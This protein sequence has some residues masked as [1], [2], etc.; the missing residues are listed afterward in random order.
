M[1]RLFRLI[2]RE[3]AVEAEVDAELD[4][5]LAL[6]TEALVAQ[7]LSRQE[8]EQEARRQFGPRAAV[9]RSTAAENRASR[10]R[11]HW[12]EW[13]SERIA[14]FGIAGRA[15]R[16]APGFVVAVTLIL[17][18]GIGSSLAA[19]ALL[20]RLLLRAVPIPE[21]DRVVLLVEVTASGQLRLPSFPTVQDW[22][23][24]AGAFE[25]IAYVPGTGIPWR[26]PA[27]VE[28]VPTAFPT[29]E[30]FPLMRTPAE[31]GR[32][33]TAADEASGDRV[34]VLSHSFWKR[35]FG[36]DPKVVGT[37][38]SLSDGAATIVGV[39]PAGF[40]VPFWA[41][42][43]LPLRVVPPAERTAIAQRGNHADSQVLGRLKPGVSIEQARAAMAVVAQRLAREYPAEQG[44]WTGVTMMPIRDVLNDP[45]R[46]GASGLTNP[47]GTVLLFAGAVGL[48]L[49]IGCA[50]VA[51]LTLVRGLARE[52]ELAIRAAIGA[53]RGAL[54]RQLLT[55]STLLAA[56]GGVLGI[57]VASLLL[58]LLK[59]SEVLPR[60]AEVELDLRMVAAT[61]AL[62]AIAA[63]ASGLVPALR[64]TP[65]AL[66]QLVKGGGFHGAT[67][68]SGTAVQRGF[69]AV[70]IGLTVTLLI[71]AALLVRSLDRVLTTPLGFD[72]EN[73]IE[74]T[75]QPRDGPSLTP[76]ATIQLYRNLRDAVARVP[77]VESVAI[78]NHTPGG[79]ASYPTR[80][81]VEGYVSPSENVVPT[82]NYR[83]VSPEYFATMRIPI[84]R[85][86]VFGPEDLAAP[87]GGLVVNESLARRYWPGQNPIGRR[88]TIF[89]SARWLPD[90]GQ[91]IAGTVIGVVGDVRHFGPEVAPPDEVFLPYT[92]T[93]W[94]WTRMVVRVARNPAQLVDPVWRA[95]VTIDPDLPIATGAFRNISP[96]AETLFDRAGPRLQMT[97]VAVGLAGAALLL[98]VVG[99]YGLMAYLVGLRSREIA[100][101]G[102]LGADRAAVLALVMREG[103]AL[104]MVGTS[105]GLTAGW[106]AASSLE[107]LVFGVAVRDL[108][109][110]IAAPVLLVGIAAVAVFIPARRACAVEPAMALKGD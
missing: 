51:G 4:S 69:V 105:L 38:M 81:E 33:L 3:P 46:L 96:V 17:A 19:F 30:F 66:A 95:V 60:I 21:A 41:D 98:A 71:G 91:P 101:R 58:G 64:V 56:I 6:K 109:A 110:F 52:R 44:D 50:N 7:G 90:F 14:E 103:L 16:R 23:I 11:R 13:L 43:Y 77:G 89:N 5:H 106:L 76:E 100:V 61:A 73:L 31:I 15:L 29:P 42:L 88:L 59:R 1:R 49:M 65:R 79:R 24:Q 72:A 9:A 34:A 93:P 84:R 63:M 40:R 54:V 57:G 86:R 99:L 87:N 28:M 94:L 74:V 35:R 97:G 102:A 36:G 108:T 75:I 32:T 80:L 2:G 12:G 10:R 67:R 25:S 39:M 107:G 37:T 20:D 55:E 45:Q 83:T 62:A 18:L 70:Q 92:W 68:R 104:T 22:Q 48:V 82:A 78:T 8:A 47:I 85:G 26:S 53:G 27:G